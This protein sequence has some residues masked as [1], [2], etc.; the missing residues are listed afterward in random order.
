MDLINLWSISSDSHLLTISCK[1]RSWSYKIACYTIIFN[2]L[3]PVVRTLFHTVW[4]WPVTVAIKTNKLKWRNSSDVCFGIN[5][6]AHVSPDTTCNIS[7]LTFELQHT[8]YWGASFWYQE[9]SM[10]H[11]EWA[12]FSWEGECGLDLF[13]KGQIQHIFFLKCTTYEPNT[14]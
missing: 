1:R 6:E 2:A 8:W 4:E 5:I 13:W 10:L 9:S 7:T 14:T 11:T 12:L 3:V